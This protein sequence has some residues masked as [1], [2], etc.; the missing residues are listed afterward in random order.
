M[1]YYNDHDAKTCAWLRELIACDLIPAGE[2]DSRSITDVHPTILAE[3]H[4]CHFFA[5]IG[6]WPLALRLAGWPDDQPVWTGSCPC[7]PFSVAGKHTGENDSRHLWP[8]FL[9]LITERLPSTIFGEQVTGASGRQWLSGVRADLETLGYAV[10]AA[11]LCASSAGAPHIRQ[12]LYWVA[13]A[14]GRKRDRQSIGEGREPNGTKG[15]RFKGDRELERGS[16]VGGLGD[17]N[18][19]GLEEQRWSLSV[20][21]EQPPPQLRGNSWSHFD[22]LPCTDGKTRRIEPGSFP[23]AHGIPARLVRL[24]GYGNAIVPQVAAQFIKAF[25]ETR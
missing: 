13:S 15:G 3:P 16:E 10:A 12:R 4:Q 25:I 23:L 1:T 20:S 7:Q 2:V 24:R 19:A 5:G 9:R 11:D 17:P 22:L 18:C 8:E 6:G 14:D 21:P